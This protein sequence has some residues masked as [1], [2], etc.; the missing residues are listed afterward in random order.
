MDSYRLTYTEA[1]EDLREAISGIGDEQARSEAYDHA[2]A[3]LAMN[4]SS[5]LRVLEGRG[6]GATPATDAVADARLVKIIQQAS[7]VACGTCGRG[8]RRV[9]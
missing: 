9:V 6:A 7:E 8:P 4:L 2:L 1:L 5:A 3:T